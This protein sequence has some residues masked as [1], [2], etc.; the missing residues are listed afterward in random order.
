MNEIIVVIEEAPDGGYG[1]RTLGQSIF[2]QAETVAELHDC[3]SDA[4]QFIEGTIA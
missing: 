1:A 3:V 4:E 2:N